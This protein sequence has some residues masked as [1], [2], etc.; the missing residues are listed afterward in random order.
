MFRGNNHL[1]IILKK[2]IHNKL[3]TY[4]CSTYLSF[5]SI[6]QKEVRTLTTLP[7][8]L[9]LVGRKQRDVNNKYTYYSCR[10]LVQLSF[11]FLAFFHPYFY[12][13]Y[14]FENQKQFLPYNIGMGEL[15]LIDFF[16]YQSGN[17]IKLQWIGRVPFLLSDSTFFRIWENEKFA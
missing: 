7:T 15:L 17:H 4:I 2:T 12:N 8:I 6:L 14:N 1:L 5:K 11:L 10:E 13:F 3:Q 16:W 9:K